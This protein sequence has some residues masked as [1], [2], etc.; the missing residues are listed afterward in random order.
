M[1]IACEHSKPKACL[2]CWQKRRRANQNAAARARHAANP[3]IERARGRRRRKAHPEKF[4]EKQHG[5]RF[6][7]TK[8]VDLRNAQKNLCAICTV[9]L[10]ARCA[11]D[12]DHKIAAPHPNI[13]GLLC[14]RCNT[15][16]GHFRDDPTLLRQAITY[17]HKH[18]T[19][20]KLKLLNNNG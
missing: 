13:R 16:L 11:V 15:G 3:E 7:T 6:G 17:L 20:H 8:I 14:S 19:E 4:R 10:I 5:M 18:D 9:E 12:H 1:T 2:E